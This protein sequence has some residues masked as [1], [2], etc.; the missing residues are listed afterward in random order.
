[1][2]NKLNGWHRI[3]VLLSAV[4]IITVSGIAFYEFYIVTHPRRCVFVYNSIP[5][6][7]VWTEKTD[8]GGKPIKPW[9]YDWESDDSIPKVRKLKGGVFASAL[10]LPLVGGWLLSISSVRSIKWVRDGFHLQK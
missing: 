9:E 7:T 1:M 2:L 4:W 5:A 10:L 3:G 8:A 6:G